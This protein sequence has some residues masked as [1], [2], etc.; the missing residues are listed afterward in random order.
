MAGA[1]IA[2]WKVDGIDGASLWGRVSHAQ[3]DVA[4][5]AVRTH[6]EAGSGPLDAVTDLTGVTSFDDAVY[7]R[8][9]TYFAELASRIEPR[10]VRHTVIVPEGILRAAIAG[11]LHLHTRHGWQIA[12]Q[13]DASIAARVAALVEPRRDQDLVTALR[14]QPA[15]DSLPDAARA[16]GVAPRTL[17]RALHGAG[18]CFRTVVEEARIA[19]A[20]R[21]LDNTDLKVEAVAREV[22][23]GSLSGFVRSFRRVCGQTPSER[24]VRAS[25]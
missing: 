13:L 15:H 7:L 9:A 8:M 24:R 20:C 18:T 12:E 1:G 2:V 6:A 3:I 22:G 14:A 11:F 21:L 23:F 4:Y 17:Q 5:A 16:L 19:E 10:L 25:S